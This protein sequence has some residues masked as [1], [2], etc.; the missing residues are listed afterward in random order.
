MLKD[1]A[2]PVFK[3]I[4]AKIERERYS[5]ICSFDLDVADA[6]NSF[7]DGHTSYST[8]YNSIFI[9]V[10]GHPFNSLSKTPD[11]DPV[12]YLGDA[13]TN[14]PVEGGDASKINGQEPKVYLKQ[15]AQS[16]PW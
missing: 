11:A 12:I 16:Q 3:V 9:F 10:H 2:K 6:L 4:Q 8:L 14:G 5:S 13:A 7:H 15:L 1:D